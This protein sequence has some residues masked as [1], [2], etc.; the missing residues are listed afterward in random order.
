MADFFADPYHTL[1]ARPPQTL[2]GRSAAGTILRDEFL[3]QIR[4]WHTLCLRLSGRNVALYSEDSLTF[5]AALLAAWQAGKTVWLT[6]DTLSGSCQTLAASVDAFLGTFP[7]E[8]AARQPVE[9]DYISPAT[10]APVTHPADF[11]ALVVHTSGSTGTAQAIPKR[12]VQLSSEVT[13]LEAFFGPRLGTAEIIATV[14]HQHIYGL[15]FKI[16]WPLAAG[17]PLQSKRLHFPEQ[18]LQALSSHDCILITSPAHLKRLPAHLPWHTAGNHLHA[19]FS[20]GGPLPA[21]TALATR[22]LLGQTPVEIYGSSETGGIAWRQQYAADTPTPWEAMPGVTWRITEEEALLEVRSPHLSDD[23]WLRLADR[24]TAQD[25][26][27]F[28]L[29]GRSDRIVKIEE[30]RIALEAVERALLAS[31]LATETRV[32]VREAAP[33]QRQTLVAFVVP[34][35][36]GQALLATGGKPLLNRH[37]RESLADTVEAVAWPRQ[38]HYLEQM[39]LDAQGK[40]THAHLLA[41]LE[42]IPEHQ[43]PDEPDSDPAAHPR[44]PRPCIPEL[45]LLEKSPLRV[46]YELTIPAALPYFEG[47]FPAAPVLP[48]VVQVD[49]AIRYG[50]QHFTLPPAFH[51][52]QALKF[53]HIIHP[54]QNVF[55]ELT[56]DDHKS[57]LNFRYFSQAGDHASGRILFSTGYGHLPDAR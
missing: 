37:L 22:T 23:G 52:I 31:G 8:W 51:G 26:R 54:G 9:T 32:I 55:L 18:L 14:S 45:H 13:M 49:W 36:E 40:I 50:R 25:E 53:Q 42:D 46:L 47:H 56:H 21:D 10:I 29:H 44:T 3:L 39:P 34:S 5:S 30:K 6:A 48:G 16:L 57:S 2:I 4:A 27:R 11:P 17:R 38:W 33:A 20:S 12:L 28:I 1:A 43:T 41:T 7:P 35:R 15:L 24:V 19:V